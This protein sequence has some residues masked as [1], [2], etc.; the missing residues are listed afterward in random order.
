M[1]NETR[2]FKCKTK[3][4]EDG[5]ATELNKVLG[6]LYT[7]EEIDAFEFY[8]NIDDDFC[9]RWHFEDHRGR[10]FIL[11]YEKTT[12]VAKLERIK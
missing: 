6:M 7:S 5:I 12:G 10:E 8:V 1:T 11:K 2:I 3:K 4:T 9:T